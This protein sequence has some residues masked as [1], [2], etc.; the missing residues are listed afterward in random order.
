MRHSRKKAF[1]L[2]EL[3]VVISIIGML[4]S[5]LLPA[6]Q[7][8][9]EAGRANTCRA[10]LKNLVLAM[11]QFDQSQNRLPGFINRVG[12]DPDKGNYELRASWVVMLLPYL[13]NAD[14]WDAWNQK[15]DPLVTSSPLFDCPSDPKEFLGEPTLSYVVNTGQHVDTSV[16]GETNDV[17]AG[18][19]LFFDR[20]QL[21]PDPGP[22]R[23]INMSM[24]YVETG[25]GAT[26]TMMI[27]ENL[28]TLFWAFDDQGFAPSSAGG[29]ARAEAS[30]EEESVLLDRQYYFGFFWRNDP[31]SLTAPF[32][33]ASISVGRIN[34]TRQLPS[35]ERMEDLAPYY[36][37]PSSNHPGGV[38]VAFCG[39]SVR[40]ITEQIDEV[41]YR[42][43][44]T[45]KRKA[46]NDESW[47]SIIDMSKL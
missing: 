26:N 41:T 11:T 29:L 33:S 28:H 21:E 22:G 14:I 40:Q 1:T 8:A 46:S 45:T 12:A 37:Y 15:H 38:H 42:Q 32:G 24:A 34:A 5:L 10:N 16:G 43:L 39:N 25:D 27:S 4:M 17:R 35:P 30:F 20:C 23:L 47:E 19:G 9:R 18:N 7:S 44:M 13:E 6:V 3:L 36:G 31:S 2:V